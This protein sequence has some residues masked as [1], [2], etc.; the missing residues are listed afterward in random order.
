VEEPLHNRPEVQKCAVVGLPDREYGEQ[1]TAF[2]VP[3]I[4]HQ[5][6]P[7]VLKSFLKEK[8]AGYC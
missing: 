2:I 4:D 8:L 7:G 6:D 5:P 3:K 1:V